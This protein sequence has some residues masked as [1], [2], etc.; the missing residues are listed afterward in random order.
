MSNDPEGPPEP[1]ELPE[2]GRQPRS[3]PP[4]MSA[5]AATG[6]FLAATLFYLLV[7]SALAALHP[8]S[9]KDVVS[10]VGC[11][12]IGYLSVLFVI[13]QVHAPDTGVRDFVGMRPTD[14]LFYGIGVGIGVALELPANALYA[15]I[16]RRW[17]SSVEDHIGAL[18]HASSSP[19]RAAIALAIILFGPMLEEVLFRGALFR[20]MLKVHPPSMVVVVTATLFAMAHFSFQAWLPIGLLGAAL[21]FLRWKSGSLVPSML[22]HVTFNAIPFYGMAAHRPDTPEVDPHVPAWL[23][24]ASG[25][26]VVVFL[27]FAYLVGRYSRTAQRAQR[28]DLE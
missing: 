3:G 19:K 6:W 21:G 1:P 2:P 13:L 25:A 28:F 17:P 5:M 15:A 22:A 7:S 8:G 20:P 23:H 12:A 27:V 16:E 18:F 4:P 11:Q 24:V 14:P 26:A 10:S 9:E